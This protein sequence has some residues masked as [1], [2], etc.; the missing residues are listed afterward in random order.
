M[1]EDNSFVTINFLLC[2]TTKIYFVIVT[3]FK[4][5]KVKT[6]SALKNICTKTINK[7]Y[8]KTH[9]AL[10]NTCRKKHWELMEI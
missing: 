7:N 6:Y 3:K 1:E 10:K 2:Y 4:K 5:I 8:I 9:V